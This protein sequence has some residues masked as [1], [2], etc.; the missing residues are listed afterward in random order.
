MYV[1]GGLCGWRA[2]CG[3]QP[4]RTALHTINKYVSKTVCESHTW[5]L[6]S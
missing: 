2:D 3:G 1:G 4:V 5:R 6:A